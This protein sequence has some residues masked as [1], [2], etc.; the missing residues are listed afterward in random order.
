MPAPVHPYPPRLSSRYVVIVALA[1]VA[2][3]AASYYAVGGGD[4]GVL[5]KGDVGHSPASSF[6][7]RRPPPQLQSRLSEATDAPDATR[8][9]PAA[10]SDVSGDVG[11][12][13]KSVHSSTSESSFSSSSSSSLA[14][15]AN[16]HLS[17]ATTPTTLLQDTYG[18]GKVAPPPV[19]V[20]GAG[21]FTSQDEWETAPSTVGPQYGCTWRVE[22]LPANA[23]IRRD[24]RPIFISR[25]GSVCPTANQ[26]DAGACIMRVGGSSPGVGCLPSLVVI[27]QFFPPVHPF[28]PIDRCCACGVVE[29][30]RRSQQCASECL[31][32]PW[33]RERS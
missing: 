10:G 20:L 30:Y 27:G 28:F 9:R 19:A 21:G 12:N 2:M 8:Q 18:A 5:N 3:V 7:T 15:A 32:Q 25:E 6:R 23:S 29:R 16:R 11:T 4:N 22:R 33:A 24:H 26:M 1:L 17:K 14:T 31:G 13:S